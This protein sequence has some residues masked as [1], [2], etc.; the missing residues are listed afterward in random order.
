LDE[1]LVNEDRPEVPLLPELISALFDK[2]AAALLIHSFT[3]LALKKVLLGDE[4]LPG[5]LGDV[6][7]PLLPADTED[8]DAELPLSELPLFD[9]FDVIAA[10]FKV[11]SASCNHLCS[12]GFSL[13]IFL[14]LRFNASNLFPDK[15][16][17]RL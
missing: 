1:T 5:K 15:N 16:E 3:A 7:D 14:K 13:H 8:P 9:W 17:H 10:G 4:Q 6:A 12:N 11:A 2:L